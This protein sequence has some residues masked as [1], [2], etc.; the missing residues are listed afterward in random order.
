MIVCR[1]AAVFLLSPMAA[2]VSG[3][4]LFVDHGLHVMGVGYPRSYSLSEDAAKNQ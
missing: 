1:Y 2:A 3:T 4:C